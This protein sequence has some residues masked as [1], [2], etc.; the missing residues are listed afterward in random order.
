M[1]AHKSLLAPVRIAT[2]R[3]P[4]AVWQANYVK[5]LILQKHPD[6]QVD[7][8]L[9]TTEGDINLSGSLAKIGGKGLFIKELE[10]ALQ[11]QRADIAVH[12]MKDM[13]ASLPT[14]LMLAAFCVREDVRDAFVSDKYQSLEQLPLN[15]IVGTSSLRR[16]SQLLR[17]RPDLTIKTLRGNVNTRLEKLAH[18]EYDAII[19]AAAGLIRLQLQHKIKQFLSVENILPAVGQAI[20]GVECRSDDAD[21]IALLNTINCPQATACI[22]AER[23]MNQFLGGDC[24]APIAALAILHDQDLSLHGRVLSPDGNIM[25][26][27]VATL[28]CTQAARLGKEIADQLLAQGAEK[29]LKGISH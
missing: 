19:L 22:T 29:I 7:L 16:Q 6:R 15:A 12:S 26:E 9:M 17:L 4:L 8:V 21:I 13:T 23:T 18:G 2:R 24:T 27:A 28:P 1:T 11:Q 20:I 5:K 14:G 3:S 10:I 25:L